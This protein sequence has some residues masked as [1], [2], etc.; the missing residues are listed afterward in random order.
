MKIIE[1]VEAFLASIPEGIKGLYPKAQ[2]LL[3]EIKEARATEQELSQ[4]RSEW[5]EA[6][7]S[8]DM[9]IDAGAMTSRG[10]DG[11][12]IWVQAWVHPCGPE[13]E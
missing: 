6:I 5:E 3:A 9:A 1:D 8:G 7:E 11:E 4:A 10:E 2:A 12:A 13:E